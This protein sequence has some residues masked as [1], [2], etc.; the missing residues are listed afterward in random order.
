[1]G[2]FFDFLKVRLNPKN[3][4]HIVTDVVILTWML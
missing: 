2:L 1:M 3:R 4:V